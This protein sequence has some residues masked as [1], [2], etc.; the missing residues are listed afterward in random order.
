ML[1]YVTRDGDLGSEFAVALPRI[2]GFPRTTGVNYPTATAAVREADRVNIALRR[3]YAEALTTMGGTA[4]DMS[5]HN[6][7]IAA[8]GYKENV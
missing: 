6:A 7:I 1:A 5:M 3:A 2:A 4:W 8:R